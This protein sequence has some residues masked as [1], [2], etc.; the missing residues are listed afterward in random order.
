MQ[1]AP[2]DLFNSPAATQQHFHTTHCT[3]SPHPPRLRHLLLRPLPRQLLGLSLPAFLPAQQGLQVALP[4]SLQLV[5]P[6]AGGVLPLPA[7]GT[8]GQE[9]SHC[10][11][12]LDAAEV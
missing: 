11:E 10:E 2:V 12:Q 8:R 4:A 9:M 3:P 6:L 7:G 1:A 5:T